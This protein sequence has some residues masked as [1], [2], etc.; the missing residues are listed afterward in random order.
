MEPAKKKKSWMPYAAGA[1]GLLGAGMY[2]VSTGLVNRDERQLLQKYID[3]AKADGA[4]PNIDPVAAGTH[5]YT[6]AADV[7][8]NVRPFGN[9]AADVVI[10]LRSST[11]TP[12]RFKI[13]SKSVEHYRTTALSP[14]HANVHILNE[15][16]DLVGGNALVENDQEAYD[17]AR[18]QAFI[19]E[20]NRVSDNPKTRKADSHTQGAHGQTHVEDTA[21]SLPGWALPGSGRFTPDQQAQFATNVNSRLADISKLPGKVPVPADYKN[22]SA[23]M[24]SATN[25]W[26]ADNKLT[27]DDLRKLPMEQ[28]TALIGQFN[29][30]LQQTAPDLYK[31]KAIADLSVGVGKTTWSS[32]YPDLIYKPVLN[33]THIANVAALGLGAGAVG[34]LGAYLYLN[35]EKRKARQESA[36]FEPAVA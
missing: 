12:D 21:A 33:A 8:Q 24:W 9:D 5:Y 15:S 7:Q 20:A 14:L 18:L 26:L 11:F 22:F 35:R 19:A 16:A 27:A 23:N 6:Q 1:I 34:L 30:H 36:V 17:K 13:N 28:Q 10:G 4:D 3:Q 29:T 25:G 2:G 32:L 31:Q